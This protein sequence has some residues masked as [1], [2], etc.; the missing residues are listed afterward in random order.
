MPIRVISRM[1]SLKWQPMVDENITDRRVLAR[2][3]RDSTYPDSGCTVLHYSDSHK[4]EKLVGTTRH[5]NL[6]PVGFK[7]SM[8][9]V[10]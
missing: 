5:T 3:P 9:V 10:R 2:C 4:T 8:S 6:C 1:C 7:N